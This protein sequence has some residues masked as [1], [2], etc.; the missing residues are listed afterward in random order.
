[1]SPPAKLPLARGREEVRAAR[2]LLEA[3]FPTQAVSHAFMAGYQAA[4][5]ALHAI[6]EAPATSTGMLS[7]FN[8][9]VVGDGRIDHEDGRILRKLFEDRSY[10]DHALGQA[11]RQEAEAAIESAE[12]LLDATSRWIEGRPAAS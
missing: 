1:V 2:A 9:Y 7:A 8:R 12:R 5:A 10:V 3:G 4:T 6:G 11:P